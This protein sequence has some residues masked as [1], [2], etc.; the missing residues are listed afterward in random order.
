MD[1][2]QLVSSVLPEF[3]GQTKFESFTRQLNGWGFT[4]LY[5][6]GPDNGCY[7]HEVRPYYLKVHCNWM[8]M[9]EYALIDRVFLEP[10]SV[11]FEGFLR[12]V[13]AK[14]YDTCLFVVQKKEVS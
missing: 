6:Q 1:K 11:F 7:Y 4:R 10:F 3:F 2:K 8:S 13:T 12:S 14:Q 5:K 9:Y